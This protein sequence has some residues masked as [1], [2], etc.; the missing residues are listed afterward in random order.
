MWTAYVGPLRR[1][2]RGRCGVM[3]FFRNSGVTNGLNSEVSMYSTWTNRA[4]GASIAT[5]TRS[6]SR[7]EVKLEHRRGP[8]GSASPR[9]QQ[10]SDTICRVPGHGQ[11]AP[12]ARDPVARE[13]A[14][15][16]PAEQ[17]RAAISLRL[18]AKKEGPRF[19]PKSSYLSPGLVI[20]ASWVKCP[21]MSRFKET[22]D[23]AGRGARCR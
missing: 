21:S 4:P 14:L 19:D 7:V 18:N 10:T 22:V 6:T 2:R 17:R 13:R 12:A 23:W 5:L 3:L 8:A 11:H 15:R 16:Y 20:W 1:S 9:P